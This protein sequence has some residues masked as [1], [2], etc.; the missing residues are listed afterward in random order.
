[1]VPQLGLFSNSLCSWERPWTLDP[2]GS[3]SQVPYLQG[4]THRVHLYMSNDMSNDMC[5]PLHPHS[6]DAFFFFL[7]KTPSSLYSPN[8][9]YPWPFYC[10][11]TLDSLRILYD[12]DKTCLVI[13][14]FAVL[15][16]APPTWLCHVCAVVLCRV[17]W[18]LLGLRNYERSRCKCLELV[19]L[20]S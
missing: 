20:C 13:H 10:F 6:F 12:R 9:P 14:V 2:F 7:K 5:S 19:F 15:S 1:M 8:L 4:M 17:S 3:T 16:T 18:L 11:H